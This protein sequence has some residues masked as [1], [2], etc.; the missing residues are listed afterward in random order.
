V[1][2][3][4]PMCFLEQEPLLLLLSTGRF[5]ERIRAWVHNRRNIVKI[6]N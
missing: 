4:R 1:E 5:Q 2:D 3:S 6:K